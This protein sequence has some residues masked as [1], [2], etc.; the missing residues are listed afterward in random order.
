MTGL[1]NHHVELLLIGI[2]WYTTIVFFLIA[3]HRK[4][5][6]TNKKTHEDLI[7]LYDNI[8]YHI[9]QKQYQ[10]PTIQNTK[11]IKIPIESQQKN[12]LA[13]TKAI[14]EE[15]LAIEQT[16]GQTIVSE[17]Q[18]NTIYKITKKQKR[19]RQQKQTIGRLITLITGGI[20][21]LFW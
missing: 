15:V 9:A 8:R 14:Q 11:A 1:N 3:I 6:T 4:I 7:L 21:K 10:N 2:F 17:E 18:W 19:T 5:I 12:Y 20:Y 16:L 13:N